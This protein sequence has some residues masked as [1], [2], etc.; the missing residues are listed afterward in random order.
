MKTLMAL[1][2]GNAARETLARFGRA[3]LVRTWD[4]RFVVEGG[5]DHEVREAREWAAHFLHEAVYIGRI[6]GRRS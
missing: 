5:G 4:E 1:I 2:P 6:A 3:H